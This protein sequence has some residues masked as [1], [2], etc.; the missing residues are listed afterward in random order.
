MRAVCVCVCV[1]VFSE[2]PFI[3]PLNVSNERE[4]ERSGTRVCEV[5]NSG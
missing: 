3:S 1:C 4:T 2:G 5:M